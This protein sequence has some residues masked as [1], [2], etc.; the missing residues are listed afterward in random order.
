MRRNLYSTGLRPAYLQS[1]PFTNDFINLT[2]SER[3]SS[4]NISP[5]FVGKLQPHHVAPVA[6][7][8][9]SLTPP[10]SRSRIYGRDA[11]AHRE[12]VTLLTNAIQHSRP[13]GDGGTVHVAVSIYPDKF[14]VSVSDPGA[15][16]DL[17]QPAFRLG[18]RL[19]DALTR[20][21]NTT[22][23]RQKSIASYT[24]T[25]AVPRLIPS[26]DSDRPPARLG[27]NR[28]SQARDE[29][30]FALWSRVQFLPMTSTAPPVSATA[31]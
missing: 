17:A 11:R 14:S 2:I 29:G 7:G 6:S 30:A 16:P 20:Q 26:L 24:V 3:R 18:A 28:G 13:S 27:Q 15:G 12:R 19:I 5:T 4:T 9:F 8:R 23:T 22:I 31:E 21:I 10:L 25:V 1:P